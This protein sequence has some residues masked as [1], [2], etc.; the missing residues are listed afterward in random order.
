MKLFEVV[1]STWSYRNLSYDD[2]IEVLDMLEEERRVWIDWEENL[3]GKRGYSR[4]IYYTNIGTI[5]PDNSYLVFNAEGSILGQLSSSFVANLR[6]GDVILLGGS[7]YR[8]TNIQGT[9]VNVNSVTGYRPTV[10]SWS[11]EARSR[12]RE[13][14]KALLDLIGHTVNTLRRQND[15]RVVL[16]DAYGLGEGVSNTI[17]RHLEEHTLDSFQVPDPNRLIVEQIVSGGMPTYLI[18]SCRGRGFNTALGYF[19]A[20]LAEQDGIAVLELSFDENGLLIKTSQEVDPRRMY[21]SFQSN[22]HIEVIERYIVS[23]QIFAKRFREVAGRSLIIPK[24]IGAEEVSPQQFQQ[25]ADALLQRHRSMEDSL[26]IKEAKAEIMHGDIDIKS[27]NEFL[28]LTKES[29]ARIVHTKVPVPSRLGMSLYMSTF[30]DLLSM[31]TRAFLVKDIDPEILK[32]LLGNRSLATEL[33]D[34]QLD[35]YYSNKVPKPTNADEL[36]NLM[37]K[38]GGLDRNWENP[39]YEEKLEGISHD[40]ISSWVEELVSQGKITKLRDTGMSELDGK[41]FSNFMAEIHGTL[42]CIAEAGG[43]D[44]DDVRDL[45]TK[46]IT[47]EVATEYDGLNPVKWK[48]DENIRPS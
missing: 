14:S 4:M 46:G 5:A 34:E 16:R 10:P 3:Y 39:L 35:Q 48:R 9:R 1:T 7:T 23:T 2:F 41:W 40:I 26:L 43:K 8:V 47:Y 44:M 33:T 25:R 12:S 22:D 29:E 28:Q 6:G 27:L 37:N 21:D 15:P 30:E 32:R 20:G 31:K 38:G 45:Y 18:T 24:R 36:L 42:G 11:G 13:L 17:A 19:M